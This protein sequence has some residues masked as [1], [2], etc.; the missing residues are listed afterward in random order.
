MYTIIKAPFFH[1]LVLGALLFLVFDVLNPESSQEDN[2]IKLDKE[3]IKDISSNFADKWGSK[4]KR[5][6][7]KIWIDG[8][9]LT[10][11]YYR[12]GIKLG[13]DK[14]DATIKKIVRKKVERINKDIISVLDVKDIQLQTY[15]DEHKNEFENNATLQKIKRRVLNAYLSEKYRAAVAKQ[16]KEILKNYE[17]IVETEK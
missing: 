9:V 1:F 15:L 8:A 3:Q 6:E 16:R 12:E 17:V 4:P 10:A 13:L 11:C 7:L 2:V 14:N 5:D